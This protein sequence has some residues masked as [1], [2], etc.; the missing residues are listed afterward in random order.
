MARF[1]LP[2]VKQFPSLTNPRTQFKVNVSLGSFHI[3]LNCTS[4]YFASLV[5]SLAIGV[6][7]LMTNHWT[8]NNI[9]ALLSI[10]NSLQSICLKQFRIG[11]IFLLS[12]L[13][14]DVFWCFGTNIMETV[15]LKFHAPIMIHFPVDIIHNGWHAK[16]F[17]SLG[18]GDI[19]LPG[20]F[21][22]M[23]HRFDISLKRNSSLYFSATII[24]YFF[25]LLATTLTMLHFKRCQPALLYCVPV[26]VLTPI[27][28][29]TL[30]GELKKLL[31]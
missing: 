15:A 1:L 20:C 10:F 14:Y 24:A 3:L 2:I 25:G 18:T 26:C 17:T 4:N 27:L 22:A 12:F 5:P 19:L 13:A 16:V 23:L 30:R 11:I 31:K 7:Y 21:I 29:A 28:I 6:L 9:F 8:V